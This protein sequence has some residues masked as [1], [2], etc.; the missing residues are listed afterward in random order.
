MRSPLAAA[1][2]ALMLTAPLLSPAALAQ[3]DEYD[4]LP[5]GE[6]RDLVFAYCGACHSNKLVAQQGLNRDR[7]DKMLVWMVEE[8]GM[9][10]LEEPDRTYVLDY[11]ATYLG[12]DR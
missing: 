11:L 12:E 3:E 5:P 10:P 7:W 2:A 6:H 8:Q 4:G 1:F 9:Y